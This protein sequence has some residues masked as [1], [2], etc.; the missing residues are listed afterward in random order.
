MYV[1]DQSSE[2]GQ[3]L[4]KSQIELSDAHADRQRL[5]QELK[6]FQ[7]ELEEARAAAE[8][9]SILNQELE[10]KEA[11]IKQLSEEGVCFTSSLFEEHPELLS[12]SLSVTSCVPPPP[13]RT[14][15]WWALPCGGRK[16]VFAVC[17]LLVTSYPC[18]RELI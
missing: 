6:S 9:A 2:L 5:M 11:R 16:M 8:V 1:S 3:A 18:S 15:M 7:E 17:L 4:K 13:P 14:T 12:V 10:Q